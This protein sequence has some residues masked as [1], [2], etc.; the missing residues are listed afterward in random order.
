MTPQEFK[1]KWSGTPGNER[2]TYQ[3]HFR[4]LCAL[5]HQPAP[6][7]CF[8]TLTLPWPPGQV[9]VDDRW[10]VEIGVTSKTLDELPRNW[11]NTAGA[12]EE[13]LKKR[14]TTNLY[15]ERPDLAGEYA[16]AAGSGGVGGIRVG[17]G[18]GG[19]E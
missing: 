18:A 11:L 8:E 12:P 9:P 7:T 1:A 17:R 6:A 10:V 15:N 3:E 16:R 14:T 4:D 19:D 2:Q 13:Q 5:L